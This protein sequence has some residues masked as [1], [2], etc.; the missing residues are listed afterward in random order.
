MLAKPAKKAIAVARRVRPVILVSEALV[1][2]ASRVVVVVI[3]VVPVRDVV[4]GGKTQWLAW[5]LVWTKPALRGAF[6]FTKA[7][8]TCCWPPRSPSKQKQNT[9][10][11]MLMVNITSI[12]YCKPCLHDWERP[13]SE[14][15]S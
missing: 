15:I 5:L 11:W 10:R 12:M 2:M 13:D 6:L 1:D 3:V 14:P 9:T 7:F 8:A 4:T